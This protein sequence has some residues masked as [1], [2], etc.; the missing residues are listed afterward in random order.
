MLIETKKEYVVSDI[1]DFVK[2]FKL[3]K[4]FK[5]LTKLDIKKWDYGECDETLIRELL[6]HKKFKNKKFFMYYDNTNNGYFV[7]NQL[8][9]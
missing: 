8:I 3:N 1:F 9:N 4:E 5:E 7:I 6:N 2:T